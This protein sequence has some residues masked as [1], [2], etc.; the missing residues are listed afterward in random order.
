MKS[1]PLHP[2]RGPLAALLGGCWLAGCIPAAYTN[3]QA[4]RDVR[5]DSDA[6]MIGQMETARAKAKAAPTAV[7]ATSFA[8]MVG[9]L[10]Q[11]QIDQR[12]SLPMPT[13]VAEAATCLDRA[14][15]QRP[16]EAYALL[17]QKGEL[18]IVFGRTDE[19]FA[20]LR[21]SMAARPNIRAFEILGNAH[22]EANQLAELEQMCKQ[23]LPAMK[24]DDDRYIV[25]ER[26]IE[27]SGASTVEGGLRW[28]SAEDVALYRRK[29]VEAEQK[30]DAFV[31]RKRAEDEREQE[32]W[33][34]RNQE[35]REQESCIRQCNSVRS[36]CTSNCGGI[37]TGCASRCDNDAA[38]C[39]RSCR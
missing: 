35:R 31:E 21:E 33:R 14:R 7:D 34:Q 32:Q 38:N 23:T 6:Q 15:E 9:L 25:M 11:N 26:C 18:F 22:K 29:R 1:Q 20:A 13:L 19:G 12:R 39:R 17:E 3:P 2:G 27:F 4:A 37:A 16:E 10:H 5:A 30:H 28:A 8:V 24:E 36:L